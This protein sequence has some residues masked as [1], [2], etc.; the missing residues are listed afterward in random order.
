MP[1]DALPEDPGHAF[2]AFY[3]K[4]HRDR[5]PYAWQVRAARE[6]AGGQLF[7]RLGAPTGAGKTTLVECFL[8]ALAWQAPPAARTLPLRLF[9]VIDRRAV[10][11]QVFSGVESIAA[12]LNGATGDGPLAAV[13]RRLRS[14]ADDE[15]GAVVQAARWRG[16]IARDVAA[17]S[18]VIPTVV[19]STVD[20][21]GSRLLFRG[22]GTSRRSRPIDAALV[23][24]D[25][26]VILDEAH[27]SGPFMDTARAVA[28]HQLQARR[29]PPRPVQAVAVSATLDP[30]AEEATF[31]LSE[32]E[33]AEQNLDRRL[34]ATKSTRLV[35]AGSRPG[36][37][38]REAR[39]VSR[40]N[41]V[42]GV[43]ANTV[44][45]AREVHTALAA[46]HDAL[47]IIGPSRPLEREGLIPRVPDRESRE[48][49]SG[50]LFIVATQTI[51]VG[52]DLDFDA[53]VTAAAPFSSLV[54]R[55]GRLDRAGELGTSEAV[56]V[57]GRQRCPVYG[58]A[59]EEAWE[60]LRLRLGDA[61]TIDLG[62]RA[63]ERLLWREGPPAPSESPRAPLL[64]PW[65]VEALAQTT[66]DPVP[67]PAPGPFLH[68]EAALD[69]ADVQI[70]WRADLHVDDEDTWEERVEVRPPRAG[71][72]LSLPVG[73]LRRW[74]R[75][76]GAAM[77]A[78]VE[79][80]A[81]AE[82]QDE[83][84]PRI[85]VRV[86]PRGPDGPRPPERVSPREIGPGD[87]LV[88]PSRYGG[89]DEFGW[90]PAD[91][92]PVR[93]LGDLAADPP[94]L[95]VD[96]RTGAPD[97][98]AHRAARIAE[99]IAADARSPEEAYAELLPHVRS[100]LI[101]QADSL[102]TEA[103]GTYAKAYR[104]L[105]RSLPEKG[106]AIPVPEDAPTG[107]LMR[108]P[109]ARGG[110]PSTGSQD[111]GDHVRR[112]EELARTFAHSAGLE[113]RE[114]ES[115]VL[116]ARYHDV[117]KLDPRFQAWLNGGLPADPN[118]PLAKSGRQPSGRRAVTARIAAGWPQGKRH[119]A[120][121]AALVAGCAPE[122]LG[123]VDRDLVLH[124]IGTHHGQHRPF[125]PQQEEDLAPARVG[126]Q[127]EGQL[128]EH[129]SAGELPWGEQVERFV[130]LLER[131]GAWGL[132]AIE[133]AL[134]LADR[135]AS[136]EAEG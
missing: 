45:E 80:V 9:W 96:R 95:L 50:P 49:R 2:A 70:A 132:A 61:E 99:L 47:L 32:T 59:A 22:Y 21:V 98:L 39:R 30:D 94:R 31:E 82:P 76:L 67:S 118:R 114:L 66:H 93:D 79:S 87:L 15:R 135:Q 110:Q 57:G 106:E 41:G 105:E 40:G 122:R 7:T 44:N 124:L 64:C 133:A 8:F 38:A 127:I 14:H 103:G 126:A 19:C 84:A 125:R 92:R 81:G 56:V 25:S 51:E 136:V 72:L 34:R 83:V 75:G 117:G 112:V 134:V 60:W 101:Q 102:A 91:R 17:L 53:L 63:I 115:V 131:Y 116:A 43:V 12:R 62:P 120:V 52:L 16:G 58:D 69:S 42:V 108:Q 65:H 85:A 86:P 109:R 130:M 97:E 100:W 46:E 20:Q 129:T 128:V 27:I 36:G 24:T 26:L 77:V 23:G 68:G 54:Q 5:E 55:L 33:R 104:S 111:Y 107:V 18:P 78:D 48:A 10:V 90:S 13:A 89:C 28:R 73:A 71:E 1:P 11:D 35:G 3:R 123:D 29:R 88:V 121:S 4:L 74:L 6:L 119:E 113:S 37:L